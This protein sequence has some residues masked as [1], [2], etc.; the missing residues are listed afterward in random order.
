MYRIKTSLVIVFVILAAI[1]VSAEDRPSVSVV[2]FN[3]IIGA[4]R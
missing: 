3:A 4:E 2:P 1:A